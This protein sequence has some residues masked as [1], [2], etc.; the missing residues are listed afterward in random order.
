MVGGEARLQKNNRNNVFLK[1]STDFTVIHGGSH[2]LQGGGPTFPG[3]GGSR[4][5]FP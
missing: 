2:I 1:P 4:C 5:L 3:G